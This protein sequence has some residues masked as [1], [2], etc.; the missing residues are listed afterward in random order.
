MGVDRLAHYIAAVGLG[1]RE[2]EIRTLVAQ[3]AHDVQAILTSPWSSQELRRLAACEIDPSTRGRLV[4]GIMW[5]LA[6]LAVERNQSFVAGAYLCL[7][8]HS[9]LSSF[10]QALGR[11]RTSS[12]LRRHSAPG[13]TGGVDLHAESSLPPLA[14]GHRHVLFIAIINDKRRGNCLFLK[15]EPYGVAGLRNFTHHTER[16]VR[17]LARRF[18]FGGNDRVGM[19][20]ERIPDRFVRAFAEAVA[21][22]PDGLRAIAEV[23]CKGEGEGIGGMHSY[24]TTK[25]A[26]QA[27]L[28]ERTNA[29]LVTLL[30]RLESEYDFVHL[31][32]GN[33]TPE[34]FLL[35]RPLA[36][37]TST[38]MTPS[39]A[40]TPGAAAA[41]GD[42][43]ASAPPPPPPPPSSA[44]RRVGPHP[45]FISSSNQY[46]SEVK[47]RRM[48][49]DNGCDPARED[50]YRL[51]GVQLIDNV[52]QHLQLPVRTFD[53]ACTY[54]HKFRLNFRDAEY[55][56]QDAAL[57]SLFVACKVE[58][59]IKKSRD[60][61]A[62]AYSVKNPD[63]PVAPDD[64]VSQPPRA[65][66]FPPSPTRQLT[67]AS[68]SPSQIFESTGK[69]IIGLER[70]ILETIGFDF[71]TRYP[72]KL[73]VKV[74]RRV[75]G[76]GSS[77][78]ARAFFATAY[79]MCTDMYKTFVPIKRT[80][81]TMV[82]AVVELTAR[83][84]AHA[85]A[86]ADKQ[87]DREAVVNRVRAF[88]AS[89][90]VGQYSRDAVA[91][92]MLDLLDLYVQHHKATKIGTMFDLNIF[93]DI[94]I[95]LNG[96]LDAA[97]APRY[98]YHCTKCEVADANPLVP[99]SAM[100]SPTAAATTTTTNGNSAD[101]SSGAAKGTSSTTT[102]QNGAAVPPVW[103]PDAVVRR[104]A[105]GQDGTM[106]FVFDPEAARQEQDTSARYFNE[107]FEEHE[108]EVEE[109]LPPPPPPPAQHHPHQ[110][111]PYHHQQQPPS[112]PQRDREAAA[113]AAAGG[114]GGGPGP[115]RGG[116][117]DRGGDYRRGPYGGYRGDRGYRGR[118]RYH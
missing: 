90:P 84:R 45:G 71:R 58:D 42:T 4:T 96:D 35:P 67:L 60:I 89:R 62:A 27:R 3:G 28:P 65:I 68:L 40:D 21:N 29:P 31:R 63:K 109:P 115:Y 92:T 57:A 53:T 46:S 18:R 47:I 24:L 106:R 9:R 76:P 110:Q 107:E 95:R 33:E 82:M 81:F 36:R 118:G 116:Y 80:T 15:P 59:T 23:G 48:L 26:E 108:V 37:I 41:N 25:I 91:E 55:N 52:R 38:E 111:P 77:P 86:A 17:S 105:R 74:V 102:T 16:Y 64:K 98:L 70:L 19:R 22:L 117:R 10:Y 73:L 112:E 44:T 14:N 39:S 85:A 50:N 54:F 113:A 75:L 101:P 100:A 7:D 1:A 32:F 97:A 93:I 6:A 34:L 49:K 99:V 114:R 88:A 20:K 56:Y 79:A 5:F 51:Q 61:L 69:V 83:M 104:T 78:D 8:P 11:P 30:R 12:H 13:C 87:A 72:Q 66:P 103:P 2:A 43:P 94:K